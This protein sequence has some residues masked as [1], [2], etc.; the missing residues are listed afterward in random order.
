MT[1]PTITALQFPI[2]WGQLG[3]PEPLRLDRTLLT[4]GPIGW[5]WDEEAPDFPVKSIGEPSVGEPGAQ[6]ADEG[7][8]PADWLVDHVVVLVPDLDAA[9]SEMQR[10]GSDLRLKLAVGG[11]PTAFFRC[12][13]VLEMIESPVRAPSLFGLALVTEQPLE[14]VVL[15]WRGLGWDVSDPKPAIQQGRRI[16]S[17]RGT[18][19]GLA[20]MSP[21]R[22]V[23]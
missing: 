5:R 16:F 18:D 21:E 3:F 7:Q 14:V 19:A 1:K 4:E 22:A 23:G 12:G 20:V 15:R 17:V 8:S 9:V 13:P 6:S 10:I 11:R 2:P